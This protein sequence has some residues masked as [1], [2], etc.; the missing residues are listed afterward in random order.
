MQKLMKVLDGYKR[1]KIDFQDWSKV[2]KEGKVDWIKDAV[3]QIGL[4]MSRMYPSLSD[5]YT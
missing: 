4:V 5:A 3:Q 2:L 1:G